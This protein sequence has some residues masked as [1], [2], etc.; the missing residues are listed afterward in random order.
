MK[1]TKHFYAM[2]EVDLSMR[3]QSASMLECGCFDFFT[4]NS[5][6]GIGAA[7]EILARYAGGHARHEERLLLRFRRILRAARDEQKNMQHTHTHKHTITARRRTSYMSN[8]VQ[9]LDRCT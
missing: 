8:N 3:D 2:G 4:N 7:E 1:L 9:F 6:P 5:P